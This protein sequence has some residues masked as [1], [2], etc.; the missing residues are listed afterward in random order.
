LN[1]RHLWLSFLSVRKWIQE[2]ASDVS[3]IKPMSRPLAHLLLSLLLPLAA[4]AT[5]SAFPAT[6]PGVSEIKTLPAGILLEISRP[7]QLFRPVQ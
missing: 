3:P 2:S 1:L 5:E 4:M 7:W 6:A